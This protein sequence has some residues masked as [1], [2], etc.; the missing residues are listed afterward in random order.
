MQKNAFV[1]LVETPKCEK[2]GF[3]HLVEAP[4]CKET[5]SFI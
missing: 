5:A 1:H 3:V 4:K 2:K